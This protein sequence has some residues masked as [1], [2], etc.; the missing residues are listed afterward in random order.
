VPHIN[1]GGKQVRREEAFEDLR[2]DSDAQTKPL[3]H[4]SQQAIDVIG[5]FLWAAR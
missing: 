4:T 1:E 2:V 3:E 5:A